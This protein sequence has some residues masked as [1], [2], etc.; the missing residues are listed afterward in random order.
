MPSSLILTGGGETIIID[1][2][3][4]DFLQK[5]ISDVCCTKNGPMD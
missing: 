2:N 1:E 5:A 4:F 3:N